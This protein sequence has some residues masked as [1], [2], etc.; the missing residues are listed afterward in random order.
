MKIISNNKNIIT[1]K[2]I[3]K[4]YLLQAITTLVSKIINLSISIKITKLEN[5]K[6]L[7]IQL[8]TVIDIKTIKSY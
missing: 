2:T 8:K 5:S 1:T 6:N 7:R 4:M 3:I